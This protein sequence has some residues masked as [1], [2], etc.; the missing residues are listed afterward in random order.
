M[1]SRVLDAASSD[2]AVFAWPQKNG[3]RRQ[4]QTCRDV[5]PAAAS[6]RQ[7]DLDAEMTMRARQAYEAGFRE[8]EAAAAGKTQAQE[9]EALTR[10]A[11]SLSEICG[12]RREVLGRA[13]RDTV[14]L[15]IE[16]ARRILHRELSV[17]SAALEALASAALDKLGA[18]EIYRVRVHPG[19]EETLRRC[20]QNRAQDCNIEVIGDPQ[21]GRGEA[22]FETKLGALDASVETQLREIERGLT[23]LLGERS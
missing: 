13:E 10:L 14:R 15:A 18:Q 22:V 5:K 4:N 20:L 17:D 7:E 21:R 3:V 6:G 9:R 23:D 19:Q 2:Y 16:I 8:G 12:L 1:L 11:T